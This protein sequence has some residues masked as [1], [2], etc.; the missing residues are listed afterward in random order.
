MKSPLAGSSRERDRAVSVP[1]GWNN[2]GDADARPP[3]P[4]HDEDQGMG[5]GQGHAALPGFGHS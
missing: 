4:N 3:R 2:E 1:E 5:D